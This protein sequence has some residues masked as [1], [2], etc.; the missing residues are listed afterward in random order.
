MSERFGNFTQETYIDGKEVNDKM[1]D[2]I[3]QQGNANYNY[4]RYYHKLIRKFKNIK[5]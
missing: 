3:S 4:T 1:L 2:I 5:N